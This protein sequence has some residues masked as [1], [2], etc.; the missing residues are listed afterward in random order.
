[1][2]CSELWFASLIVANVRSAMSLAMENV[3][4]AMALVTLSHKR[5]PF[6]AGQA[7]ANSAKVQ[8][9]KTSGIDRN[10]MIYRANK[11][12]GLRKLPGFQDSQITSIF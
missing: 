4:P 12:V 10:M 6:A 11:C 3:R 9:A 7:I 5:A 8:V 2:L 1:M